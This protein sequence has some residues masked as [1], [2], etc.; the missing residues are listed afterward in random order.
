MSDLHGATLA[1][2]RGRVILLNR[3]ADPRTLGHHFDVLHRDA[4]SRRR[5]GVTGIET[6]G[7]RPTSHIPT[8]S[9]PHE[10]GKENDGLG[11]E[12]RDVGRGAEGVECILTGHGCEREESAEGVDGEEDEVCDTQAG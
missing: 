1:I 2:P 7:R 11:D 9:Q 3:D 10:M 8:P 4:L 12:D 6:R 5:H